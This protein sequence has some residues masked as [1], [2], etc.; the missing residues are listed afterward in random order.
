[1]SIWTGKN[2]YDSKLDCKIRTEKALSYDHKL[3]EID[4]GPHSPTD[5]AV[6]WLKYYLSDRFE[7]PVRKMLDAGCGYGRW[8]Q[9]LKSYYE[10]YLG[11]DQNEDRIEY[12]LDN[13]SAPGCSFH[14]VDGD[15]NLEEKFDVILS[16][17][18]I[19]HLTVQ[20]TIAFL[21]CLYKHLADGGAI[22]LH[23]GR[24]NFWDEAK[25]EEEYMSDRCPAHMIYKPI[26]LLQDQVPELSWKVLEDGG[27]L[28][29]ELRKKDGQ[30]N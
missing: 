27:G 4:A 23:E 21:K 15:W 14:H 12:A 8:S 13:F 22:V 2:G 11:V 7:L 5:D 17:M 25:A 30:D 18:T 16:L 1:M 3:F 29:Y 10:N 24:L 20:E 19:Q 9:T 26:P 6:I 28:H